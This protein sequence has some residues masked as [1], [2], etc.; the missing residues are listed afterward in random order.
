M[1]KFN[2]YQAVALSNFLSNLAVAW[3]VI[4]ILTPVFT[5]PVFTIKLFPD[6]IINLIS[7]LLMLSLSV[8]ILKNQKEKK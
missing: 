6:F 4:G 8:Y 3:F 5:K 2:L 7:T 1:R